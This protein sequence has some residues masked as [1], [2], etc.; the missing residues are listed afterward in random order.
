[1]Q[2]FGRELMKNA[3]ALALIIPDPSASKRPRLSA[4]V[5]TRLSGAGQ[6]NVSGTLSKG[7]R[8]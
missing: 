7:N 2:V 6:Q 8:L 5:S 1:M 4:G 3:E